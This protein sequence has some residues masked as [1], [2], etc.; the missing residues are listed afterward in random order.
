MPQG[1]LKRFPRP[2]ASASPASDPPLTTNELDTPEDDNRIM[3]FYKEQ[4]LSFLTTKS[5]EWSFIAG[6]VYLGRTSSAVMNFI[7]ANVQIQASVIEHSDQDRYQALEHYQ[8]GLRDFA[9]LVGSGEYDPLTLLGTLF[10]LV[11]F[12]LRHAEQAEDIDRHLHGFGSAVLV[13]GSQLIPGLTT[14]TTPGITSDS[15]ADNEELPIQIRYQN[16]LNRLGLWMTYMD[17][18]SSTWDLGGSV[19]HT[20]MIHYPGSIDAIF[21]KSRQAGQEIWGEDYPTS[22]ALDDLQNRPAFDLYHKAHI[23]RYRVTCYRRSLT[24]STEK[25]NYDANGQ[26]SA[27]ITAMI[28]SLMDVSTACPRIASHGILII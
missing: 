13:H 23:L 22:E 16:V 14:S 12:E 17:A 26:L 4:Y 28:E 2:A 3:R 18:I 19:M 1:K 9:T 27:E 15:R 5:P 20:F 25:D 8:T 7:M 21:A 24:N 11:Q 10:L 6:I